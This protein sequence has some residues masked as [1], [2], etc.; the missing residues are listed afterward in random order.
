MQWLS[1]RTDELGH[2]VSRSTISE[3]E[4]GKRQTI[5]LDAVI[6]LAAALEASVADLLYP[7]GT[8][9]VEVLPGEFVERSKAVEALTGITAGIQRIQDSVDQAAENIRSQ[10]ANIRELAEAME[11]IKSGQAIVVIGAGAEEVFSSRRNVSDEVDKA[12][13][14]R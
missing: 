13:D 9:E 2:P 11:Q 8:D 3:L 12:H 14:G 1:D 6:V 10:M 4:N 7:G 5:S